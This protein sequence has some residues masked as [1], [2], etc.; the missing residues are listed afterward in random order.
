MRAANV[1]TIAPGA[2][3]LKTFVAAL[4]NGRV[5]EGFTGAIDPLEIADTTIYVPTRRAARA[6]ADE[7]ARA[8]DKPATLLPRILPLGALEA[9]E[10]S[11]LFSSGGLADAQG[12]PLP[13]AA[14]EIWRRMQLAELI[15]KWSRAVA[16]A[17]VSI[18]RTGRATTDADEACLV[19]TSPADAWHLAGKLADLIDEM[20][21]EDVGWERLDPLAL[22]EFDPYWGITINFLNIAMTEW[23]KILA[24]HARV[25]PARRQM[26]LVDAQSRQLA[27]DAARGPVIAIG[28]TGTNKATARLLASI[29]RAAKA[30]VVLPGLDLDLADDAW[31]LI[32][33]DAKAEIAASFS[34]PQSALSRLLRTLGITRADVVAL[35]DVSASR[36]ARGRFI[37]EALRPADAT[38]HWSLYRANN[39]PAALAEALKDVALIEAADEGEEALA[40]ALVLRELL[41]DPSATAALVTP[42][43]DLSRRVRADLLRWDIS[44]DDS[45]G[46]PLNATSFGRLAMP[47]A[48]CAAR[49]LPPVDL[50]A[51]IAHPL[52]CFGLERLRIEELAPAFEIGVLRAVAPDLLGLSP[53]TII[54]TARAAA[55]DRFAH[56]AKARIDDRM[57]GALAD[58]LRRVK[59]SLRPLAIMSGLHGLDEWIAAHRAALDAIT[60]NAQGAL[61]GGRDREALEALFDELAAHATQ[62]MAFDGEAYL[63]F[64]TRV[65]VDIRQEQPTRVHPRIKILGLLEARLIEADLMI[66]GGLDETIWPPQAETDPFLNRPMRAA[67]GLTPPERRLGQTAHDFTQAM[68]SRRVVLSRALK[69][70]GAPTVA[71]RFVQRLAALGDDA[72]TACLHRGE[73]YVRLAH[74]LHQPR[75]VPP[76]IKRPAPKPPLALRPTQLSVTRI[77]RLRRD[78]YAIY[79]EYILHLPELEPLGA[80]AGA[81]DVGNIFH[82]VLKDFVLAHPM[83][84]LPLDAS[85]LLIETLRA[86]LTERLGDPDFK[87][88]QWPRLVSAVA[89][90]LQFEARRRAGLLQLAVEIDGRQSIELADGSVFTLTARADR[91]EHH[92]DGCVTLIDYKTGQPP[93]AKEVFAGFAP[94]LTLEAAMARRGAFGFPSA[95]GGRIDALDGLYLK[96]GGAAGGKE[97][98]LAFKS[99]ETFDVVAERHYENLI[100]LLGEFRDPKKGYI[101][102][103]FPKFAGRPGAYDHLARVKEWALAGTDESEA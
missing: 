8:L 82:N 36:A 78:P 37:S 97:I 51:L 68:G 18:D 98:R 16:H 31:A 46:E 17:I 100:V 61:P 80:E 30:A 50:V 84:F 77:E 32:A 1:F 103:P 70:G 7:L 83:G 42:D 88:F 87:A 20:I 3:F 35:G 53:E 73:T 76:P 40:I 44:I 58:L 13:Q 45:G 2:P 23:P 90:Y 25:D 41:E 60:R 21:I 71:S 5:V 74:M 33:G 102:R 69:R 22:P 86:A 28:S 81:S 34:H 59:E 54:A 27:G 4:I 29:S 92:A 75:A 38:D 55:Q 39:D 72:W 66:L 95:E 6:L 56:P 14:S 43:R 48:A 91:I 52:A 19:A 10:T 89:V 64:L 63:V 12:R 9:T 62:S 15:L 47:A 79:A 99:G 93:S 101:S 65:C 11:L 96:L 85:P 24:A 49:K 26:Q 57:W 94:Q 67:L